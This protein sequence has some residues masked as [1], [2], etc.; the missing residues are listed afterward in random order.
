M[1]VRQTLNFASAARTPASSARIGTRQETIDETREVLVTLFGLRHTL[2]TKVGN[3]IV[4]GVSGGE[5]KRVS[6]AELVGFLNILPWS[7]CLFILSHLADYV[8]DTNVDDDGSQ[9]GLSR[10]FN[11]RTRRFHRVGIYSSPPNC[12]RCYKPDN[13]SLHLVRD[14]ILLS[15]HSITPDRLFLLSQCG[16]QIYQLFDKVCVLYSGRMVYFGPMGEAVEHFIQMGYEP[17]SRQ[18]SADF[19]VAVT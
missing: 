1:T 13:Y 3:D 12:D 8:H 2:D 19:L 14:E 6:I 7:Y 5:R 17:Q 18:T 11:S 16:E 9:I 10:Q 4:R 15:S